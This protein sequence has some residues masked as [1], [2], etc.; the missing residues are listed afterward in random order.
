MNRIQFDNMFKSFNKSRSLLGEGASDL[1]G[2]TFQVKGKI[3]TKIEPRLYEKGLFGGVSAIGQVAKDF[4]KRKAAWE[5]T[6]SI[7]RGLMKF[8]GSEGM[9]ELIQEASSKGLEEY[10]YD[11]Y[12]GKKGYG[13][14]LDAVLSN[15]ENPIT[16]TQGMKTFLMGALTG[17]LIAPLSL[18]ASTI[19]TKVGDARKLKADPEYKTAKQKTTEAVQMMNALY[20]DPQ[21]FKKEALANI[22]VNNKAAEDM[23]T[24]VANRD[25]YVFNNSKDSALAKTVASAIKLDMYDSLRD[26][27]AEYG[28][29]M[30]NEEF[31]EAFGIDPTETNKKDVKALTNDMISNIEDYY[32]TFKVLKDKYSDLIIPELYKNN[33]EEVYN[34]VKKQ[35][36]VLDDTIELIA[37]N[38]FKAKQAI[39]RASALQ[40]ELAASK[41]IG[42]SSMQILTNLSGDDAIKDNI[43]ALT[44]EIKLIENAV[45][46]LTRQQQDILDSKREELKLVKE[47]KESKSELLNEAIVDRSYRAYAG[48]INLYNKRA[49]ITT[50]VSR[51]DIEDAFLKFTD[52]IKLNND[53]REYVD[54]MNLLADPKNIKLVAL[55]MNSAMKAM[56][57]K[58][59]E[60]QIA[61]L[62]AETGESSRDVPTHTVTKEEDGTFT[63]TSPDGTEVAAGIATE[64]EANNMKAEL[65]QKLAE[66][67]AK[68][69]ETEEEEEVDDRT[70]QEKLK[71]IKEGDSITV[72]GK[73]AKVRGVNQNIG[74]T[75]GSIDIEYPYEGTLDYTTDEE[76]ASRQDTIF[77][78]KDGKL[79]SGKTGEAVTIDEI[80]PR[81]SLD[82]LLKLVANSNTPEKLQ[83]FLE[84]LDE[85]TEDFD[86]TEEEL[87]KVQE[88]VE[89]KRKENEELTKKSGKTFIKDTDPAFIKQYAVVQ[90]QIAEV[91]NKPD[92]TEEEVKNIFKLLTPVLFKLDA[93]TREGYLKKHVLQRDQ[94][95]TEIAKEKAS[96]DVA[97]AKQ[98]ISLLLAADS[99]SLDTTVED[100]FNL[101]NISLKPEFKEEV[102]QHFEQEYL[103]LIDKRIAKLRANANTGEVNPLIEKLT[104]IAETFE[105]KVRKSIEINEAKAK[106]LADKKGDSSYIVEIESV[107]QNKTHRGILENFNGDTTP[108]QRAA[109]NSFRMT[110][111][112][113]E[114][115]LSTHDINTKHG[116]SEVINLAIAR[117]YTISIN[118][119]AKAY[120]EKNDS[121]RLK[122]ILIEYLSE[123]APTYSEIRDKKAK[124]YTKEEIEEDVS[125]YMDKELYPD[126]DSLLKDLSITKLE[127][128]ISDEEYKLINDYKRSIFRIMDDGNVISILESFNERQA[129]LLS[130]SSSN[131]ATNIITLDMAKSVDKYLKY[132]QGAK[133]EDLVNKF[134]GDLITA[135]ETLKTTKDSAEGL[136]IINDL[137][138]K[139]IDPKNT[140]GRTIVQSL[141]NYA[142]KT[143]NLLSS[144]EENPQPLSEEQMK[145]A[146]NNPTDSLTV[147]QIAQLEQFAKTT[148]LEKIKN[149]LNASAGYTGGRTE[150]VPETL[151]MDIN[152]LTFNSLR[153][154]NAEDNR[155]SRDIYL[156]LKA[157]NN[158]TPVKKA[159]QFIL[160]SEFATD[161]E[162][163]LAEKL[164]NVANDSDVI[165]IDN[166]INALGE[167]D[168]DTNKVSINLDATS[169]DEKNPDA[170]KAPIETVILHELMHALTQKAISDP[171]SEYGK[172]VRSLFNAVK[173]QKGAKTFYAFQD[174]LTADEQLHE[175]VAEAFTNPAFQYMLA[176]TP[177]A[178]SKLT[179]WD[180]LMQLVSDILKAVGIDISDTALSEILSL[181]DNLFKKGTIAPIRPAPITPGPDSTDAKVGKEKEVFSETDNKGKTYTYYSN[182]TEKD[183]LTKTTFTF[184]RSDKDSSQRANATSGIPVEKAL[185]NKYTIDEESVPEGLKVVGVVEIRITEKGAGATVTVESEGQRWQINVKLN[186][187]STTN[188]K[189]DIERRREKSLNNTA[190]KGTSGQYKKARTVPQGIGFDQAGTLM[191]T[192]YQMSTTAVTGQ[193]LSIPQET[194]YII[195]PETPYR[196][197]M[198]EGSG[199]DEEKLQVAIKEL[200]D[201]IN[202][203][204]DAELAALEGGISTDVLPSEE[205]IEQ[206]KNAGT[207]D[208]LKAISQNIDARKSELP[209][210]IYD[211]LMAS[212]NRKMQSIVAR[213]VKSELK[214][215][216]PI[217]INGTTYYY[218]IKN[219]K[220]SVVKKSGYKLANVKKGEILREVAEKILSKHKIQD[221]LPA[222]IVDI[223]RSLGGNPQSQ[224]TYASG[225]MI[226]DGTTIGEQRYPNAYGVHIR[227]AF[228]R[229]EFRRFLSDW[230]KYLKKKIRIGDFKNLGYNENAVGEFGEIYAAVGS[231]A[232]MRK[233]INKGYITI[234]RRGT[235]TLSDLISYDT[236]LTSD[237]LFM[238]F[239]DVINNVD[240][241][242]SEY[243]DINS[244]IKKELSNFFG[245]TVSD[246]MQKQLEGSIFYA[247]MEDDNPPDD[248]TIDAP[249]TIVSDLGSAELE[250]D[251]LDITKVDPKSNI[252]AVNPN[253]LRSASFVDGRKVD[254]EYIPHPDFVKYY[255]KVRNIINRLS[256]VNPVKLANL[257]V[258]LDKDVAELRWDGSAEN[259][260]WKAAVAKE[261]GV[262]GYISDEKGN[263]IIFD[264]EGNQVGVLD[265]N[266]LADKKGLD[267]GENQ[268]VYFTTMRPETKKDTLDKIDKATLDLMFKARE[269][270]L[271]GKPQISK[272]QKIDKGQM[273]L[274]QAIQRGVKFQRN[275]IRDAAMAEGLKKDNV[276]FLIEEKSSKEGTNKGIGVLKAVVTD[277]T[278]ASSSH[279][280]F[281]P[282]VRNVKIVSSEGEFTLFE[283]MF[284]LMKLYTEMVEKEG[285]ERIGDLQQNLNMFLR[286]IVLTGNRT[287]QFGKDLKGIWLSIPSKGGKP[288]STYLTLIEFV[289]GEM[290]INQDN[291]KKVAGYVNN[292]KINVYKKW[293]TGEE[294]FSFPY[295]VEE[296][297]KKVIKFEDKNFRDFL[298]NNVGLMSYISEIPDD[299]DIM[300]YNSTVHFLQPSD[301]IKPEPKAVPTEQEIVQN[302]DVIKDNTTISI[303]NTT[304]NDK[305]FKDPT[306]KTIFK[307]PSY[308][309]IFEKKCK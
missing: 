228:E 212:V 249:F 203:K 101:L 192:I 306:S 6:K 302:P 143:N 207:I 118:S 155:S 127:D 25:R 141:L 135:F 65:D 59:L 48:L 202:A 108:G 1:A 37:S 149:K 246:D 284:E 114:E 161:F 229:D 278:G 253:G 259:P 206:I 167:F 299:V 83:E 166:T 182:T 84:Y 158:E 195:T 174:S 152:R 80:T 70:I 78:A 51:E 32:D 280:L 276:K 210:S 61:E 55:A 45:G 209:K 20:T 257:H 22:K 154:K 297:G 215:Y 94:I 295:I 125:A 50:A 115:D 26:M 298:I 237:E 69:E 199:I 89:N 188:A 128:I 12:H 57:K 181:T 193:K 111:M 267:N 178:N 27:I 282:N 307:S 271:A 124:P 96:K 250:S 258:T 31:K 73:K 196:K 24:A 150:F 260:E 58:F 286:N 107:F 191:G 243:E 54:A 232:D 272:L 4:G 9:Q 198:A 82:D 133:K 97:G 225:D 52:Y 92:V 163:A 11:L 3:G 194:S 268:I 168:S 214:T 266:N 77:V 290:K 43:N 187:N 28:D 275:T 287:F 221:I 274:K 219:G 103:K 122:N 99:F 156:Q 109:I 137:I 5:A 292:R 269:A 142:L 132:E 305:K 162:K 288:I 95:L 179:V 39:K 175:F 35:K 68:E 204:Y 16:S 239:N 285:V 151:G 90:Q 30:S 224:G 41:N 256:V 121:S 47:W 19:A 106:E 123:M 139:H 252:S 75:V 98:S 14:K 245:F 15:I 173:S 190:V 251:S 13:D 66:E 36:Q 7:G 160:D 23:Q 169:Y 235:E 183:G 64:E 144:E 241:N 291:L 236:K 91:V 170:P 140:D 216:E 49:K 217:K 172:A 233:L 40:G 185:E 226:D 180:K 62:E 119:A 293:L 300:R 189:V 281:T 218:R 153:Q 171:N 208:Q 53:S 145:S 213:E 60:E 148:N 104:K 56:S 88:A 113:V 71:D 120:F 86:F 33:A 46:P 230:R 42:G 244:Y 147:D 81:V 105:A 110:G 186:T 283:H 223:I 270:V 131:D 240:L 301:L 303:N 234:E 129:Q 309:D 8:E 200:Q 177:Y 205:F 248:F 304:S 264:K 10:Y 294:T 2:R 247:D 102:I 273:D 136:K 74:G 100:I 116:A 126:L 146:I 277:S 134:Y 254:G 263:P 227:L 261:Q 184:N 220:V 157:T 289:N 44:E 159:L 138:T 130:S 21:W 242:M 279:P 231:I 164:M 117:M 38:S 308:E 211:A 17:R 85:S 197:S 34:V 201:K 63:I 112:I 265:R 87:N 76:I 238:M 72:N 176:K 79:N 262:I 29:G 296:D 18:G 67:L 93:E 222:N 165:T 255:H